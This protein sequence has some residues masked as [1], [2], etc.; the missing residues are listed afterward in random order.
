MSNKNHIISDGPLHDIHV[1]SIQELGDLYDIV[2]SADGSVW[3]SVEWKTFTNLTEWAE[4][5]IEINEDLDDY[6]K[7]GKKQNWNDEY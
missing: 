3:D 2:I 5:Y 1:L 7:I 4:Y 6:S